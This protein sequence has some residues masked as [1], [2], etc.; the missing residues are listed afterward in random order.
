MSDYWMKLAKVTFF[1]IF[2]SAQ[3]LLIDKPI[4]KQVKKQIKDVLNLLKGL[5]VIIFMN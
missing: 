3:L 4:R 2:G 5:Y 1:K